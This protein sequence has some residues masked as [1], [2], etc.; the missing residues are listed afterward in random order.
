MDADALLSYY[1][2][3]CGR[4]P[5]VSLEDGFAEDDWEGFEAL[6][7]TL[8]ER[9]HVVGDDLLVTN[10]ARLAEAATKKAVNAAILK[11]NQVGT[12]METIAAKTLVDKMGWLAVASHRSGET[13][14]T[15]I[16]DLAVGL[17]CGYIKAGSLARGERV[18]KYNRLLEI[19]DELHA[20]H[21][22][23]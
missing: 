12:V 18:C 2:E 14:D 21:A 15:A 10:V 7:R 5:I 11:P 17:S 4:Y 16:A 8:G 13:N 3:L 23:R 20:A 6:T 1:T 9:V 22:E 19:E